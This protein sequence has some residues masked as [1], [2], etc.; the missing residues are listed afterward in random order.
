MA[1]GPDLNFSSIQHVP[2]LILELLPGS[3]REVVL[4]VNFYQSTFSSGSLFGL[5]W[6]RSL[7]LALY[8]KAER[9]VTTFFLG[10][11]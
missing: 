3:I 4:Y 5:D 10:G 8:P 6:N 9:I 2:K 1:N 11:G 7:T